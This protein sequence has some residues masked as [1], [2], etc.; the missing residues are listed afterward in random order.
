MKA[1]LKIHPLMLAAVVT[2][3][4]WQSGQWLAAVPA[5]ALLC[6]SFYV[7][8]RWALTATQRYRVADFCTVL[9]LLIGAWLWVTYGNPSAVILFF[10]WLPS[11]DMAVAR[12][13]NRV[14]Q[15]GHGLPEETIRN[16]YARGIANFRD[17]YR[18]VVDQWSCFD[19]SQL[20]PC[21]VAQAEGFTAEVFEPSTWTLIEHFKGNNL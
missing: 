12:V 16:R 10:L 20:P 13:A 11:A 21:L 18:P 19:G 8:L 6:A 7:P 3:W 17:L 15:G 5:A 1:P 4:G 2:F 14:M 9:A